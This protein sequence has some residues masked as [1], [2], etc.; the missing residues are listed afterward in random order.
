M[1]FTVYNAN[2][3]LFCIIALTLETSAL[4]GH[5]PVNPSAVIQ[6]TNDVDDDDGFRMLGTHL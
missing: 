5:L 2:V 1:E 6:K 3:N 4:G